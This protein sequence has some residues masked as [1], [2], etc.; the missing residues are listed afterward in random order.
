MKKL[1]PA[2]LALALATPFAALAQS[3]PQTPPSNT[4]SD[5]AALRQEIDA[6]RAAYEARLQAMEQRLKA[7]E[8]AVAAAP[9]T[10][11]AAA[12]APA[13]A[14][15]PN[16]PPPAV[17]A[18][19]G[20]ANA[21]NP[22]ISL[23]LSGLYTRTSKDPENFGIT[24]FQLPGDAEVGPGTRGFS[25]AETEL[26]L[27]A[28]IDPWWR[29]SA[30]I[31]LHP[32]NEVS[33][34]EA[35]VQT[36]SLGQGFS[37]KAG[38]FFSGIGY[39]NAQHAHT[40]DFVDNPLA[41]Q[42]MLGTQFGD[43]GLQ[44][45]WLAPID[46]YLELGAEVGRGRSFPGTDTSRNGAGMVALTAHAGG[47][48]GDSHSWRAGLSLLHAKADD[49]EL[50]ATD[51][52][53]NG[54]T[55]AFTGKTRVW[56]A[57]AVWKWA[58]NGN[59]TRTS[60]KLQGEYLH[61]TRDG[62]LVYDVGNTDGS[63][64]FRVVQSG[65]YLQGIY[66][67][68]PGWRVGLRTERLDAGSPDFGGSALAFADSNFHPHKNTLMLDYNPSEFSRVRLQFAQDRSRDG[69]TDNQFFVQYQ[70]S[71]GAHGAHSY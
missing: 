71:L 33:V 8:A 36:T 59:A 38:R 7:A 28:N 17:A 21:F 16:V 26:G 1:L 56:V 19:G 32:D 4:S 49:Q 12:A 23:I 5:I 50:D 10:S 70:M 24:G 53:G 58:P 55:N 65:W 39:L 61:G 68:M 18:A 60:F 66:Q 54:V 48:I 11:D 13:A 34:E 35:F 52:A 27:S 31:A 30:N 22:A 69:V 15:V 44:L 14:P 46:Q 57:D 41:Y 29:G 2:S 67:F 51:A 62:S 45:T 40:W 43:D 3:P 37:L 6:M 42:A 25:L 9:A 47:D 64:N 63:G 20:G